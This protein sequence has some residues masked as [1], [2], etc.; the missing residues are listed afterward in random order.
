MSDCVSAY[1]DEASVAESVASLFDEE[2]DKEEKQKL[3]NNK[4]DTVDDDPNEKYPGLISTLSN[5]DKIELHTMFKNSIFQ[6]VS[7]DKLLI[8]K[9]K[10]SN[11]K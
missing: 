5:Q 7:N 6:D 2:M 3:L 4:N 8:L 9:I 1:G 10:K 11:S